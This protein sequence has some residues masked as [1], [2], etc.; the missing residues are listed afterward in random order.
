MDEGRSVRKRL[1]EL[2]RQEKGATAVEY[3]LIIAL[4][5]LAM[6]SGFQ[7]FSD[8]TISMWDYVSSSVNA[9]VG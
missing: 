3:G 8:R 7:A 2:A 4:M 9:V 6:L 1:R 5:V